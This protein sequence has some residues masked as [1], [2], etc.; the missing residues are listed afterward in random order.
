MLEAQ[1]HGD[2]PFEQVVEIV[3]PPRS[4]AHEPIFQTMFAWQNHEEDAP[5]LPG[6]TTTPLRSPPAHAKYDLTLNLA[7]AGGRIV[8]ELEYAT[9]LFDRATVERHVA[10]LGRLLAAMAA[11]ETRAIDRLPL[12]DAEERHRVLVEWNA[13]EADYPLDK[14]VH[15]LVEAQAAR[16]PDAIAVVHDNTQLTYA[17]LNAKANRLAR[18]LRASGV[19]PNDRVAAAL[20]RSV[21]LVLAQLAILKCGAA[22]VPLDP[23]APLQ[24]QA[25]MIE[26]C[27]ARVLLAVAGA[28]TPE[29][30]GGTR[31]DLDHGTFTGPDARTGT[32]RSTERR[33]LMSCTPRARRPAQRRGGSPPGDRAARAQQRLSPTSRRPTVSPLRPTRPSTP[34]RWKCGRRCSTAVASS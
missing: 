27:E 16:T 12:L 10:Y 17:E 22:Y 3:R 9:A 31:V 32:R 25:F 8:G 26:D 21:E 7:E 14:G 11:N 30:S 34:A 13:T 15:E 20:E 19:R 5:D 6:L 2:L 23:I 1:A 28:I 4:L 24:R 33:R 29:M 18:R